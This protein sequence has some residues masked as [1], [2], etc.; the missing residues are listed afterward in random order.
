MKYCIRCGTALDDSSRFCSNCGLKQPLMETCCRP[1]ASGALEI[2]P[3][4]PQAQSKPTAPPRIKGQLPILIWSLILIPVFNPI[5]TVLGAI[6]SLLCLIADTEKDLDSGFDKI[7]TA[8]YMCIIA[9][10]FDIGTFVFFIIFIIMGFP[11]H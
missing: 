10:V 3:V 7:D 11:Q 1:A 8:L 9:T 4:A 2:A 6:A 5:G